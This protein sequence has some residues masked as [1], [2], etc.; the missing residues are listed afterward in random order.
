[1]RDRYLSAM[2][3]GWADTDWAALARVS[4]VEAGVDGAVVGH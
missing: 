4:A 3:W 2:A 1:M